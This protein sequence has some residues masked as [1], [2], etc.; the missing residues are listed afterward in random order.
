MYTVFP[1]RLFILFIYFL[2]LLF[3]LLPDTQ[4]IRCVLQMNSDDCKDIISMAHLCLHSSVQIF[5]DLISSILA[6][7]RQCH[8]FHD[9]RMMCICGLPAAVECHCHYFF[10]RVQPQYDERSTA[11]TFISHCMLFN[12]LSVI[13]TQWLEDMICFMFFINSNDSIA[14]FL[15]FWSKYCVL[16]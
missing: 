7:F 13:Y 10:Q 12:F 16:V 11:I 8:Y 14:F 1:I 5:E 9:E 15:L 3:I 6:M 2:Q 4:S